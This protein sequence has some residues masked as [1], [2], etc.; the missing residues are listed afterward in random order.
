MNIVSDESSREN[1]K[2]NFMSN[3]FFRKLCLLW[4][5]VESFVEW[6]TPLMTIWRMRIA[7]WIPRPSDAHSGCV[8]HFVCHCNNGWTKAPQFYVTLTLPILSSISNASYVFFIFQNSNVLLSGDFSSW[9][10]LKGKSH[11]YLRVYKICFFLNSD[12]WWE[13][14]D[15]LASPWV[16]ACIQLPQTLRP[17]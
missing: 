17:E 10:W 15:R 16:C 13:T 9:F 2:T 3:D 7:C 1:Q 5:K 12:F 6:D 8:K 4:D 14:A 11:G